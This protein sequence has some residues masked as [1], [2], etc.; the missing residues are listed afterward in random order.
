MNELRM[1]VLHEA[2][3]DLSAAAIDAMLYRMREEGLAEAHRNQREYP[4][5]VCRCTKSGDRDIPNHPTE[6]C[7]ATGCPCHDWEIR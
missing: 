6:A 2:D 1:R 7:E 5:C 3:E 4:L